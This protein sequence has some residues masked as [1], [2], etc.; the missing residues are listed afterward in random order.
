M[1]ASLPDT[2]LREQPSHKTSCHAYTRATTL[3]SGWT[4]SHM[5]IGRLS[6]SR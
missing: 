3:R 6:G 2:P 4:V 5:G 1:E